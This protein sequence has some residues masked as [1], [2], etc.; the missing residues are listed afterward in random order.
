MAPL[1]LG[2]VGTGVLTLRALL[3]HLTQTD[4]ADRVRVTALAD[5]AL[6]RAREAAARYGIPGVHASLEAMLEADGVDAVTIVSPIGLHH[7]HAKAALRAGKHV[8]LNKTMTTTVAEADELIALARDRD[9]RIVA[10]PGEGLRPQVQAIRQLLHSGAIG[11]VA[12]GTCGVAFGDYHET[13]AERTSGAAPIDPSWYFRR[14]GGG[15][16]YDMGSYALHQLTSI[17]GPARRVTA[18]SGIRIPDRHFGGRTM[19]TEMDD[20][21]GLLID[22]GNALFVFAYAA[23]AGAINPQF[24]AT[25]FHGTGGTLDGIL[26]NGEPIDFP[27]RED[28]LAAPVSD[29]EVQCRTLPHVTGPHRAIP[30]SHVFEDV[31][32]L[33]RWVREGIPSRATAEQ[34]RHVVEIIEAGYRAAETG[35]T[36]T[37]HTTFNPE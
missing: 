4:I 34:A 2:I 36:Q 3:P 26:L 19:A 27:G 13:E 1:R 20:N 9:L 32:Q 7:A 35:Q 18:M 30:E 33:V 28:T 10:S 24:G 5:P 12:F 15:P 22:F 16:M 29:W 23:A 31:M 8:H 21:T 14:P 11:T 17:L 6:D 37:L 25:T